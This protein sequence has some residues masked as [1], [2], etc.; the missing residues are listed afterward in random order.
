MKETGTVERDRVPIRRF[1]TYLIK[2]IEQALMNEGLTEEQ[3]RVADIVFAFNNHKMLELLQKRYK[4]LC[5]AKFEKAAIVENKLT[6][7]K[8]NQYQNLTI[9]NTYFCTFMEGEGSRKAANM[10]EIECDEGYK[11]KIEQ[12]KNPSNILWM[13]MGVPRWTQ[14]TIGLTVTFIILIIVLITY[15]VFTVEVSGQTYIHYRASP[16]GVN[17]DAFIEAETLDRAQRLASIEYKFLNQ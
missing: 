4:Y 11:L 7:L 1:K 17:C 2:M 8:N 3:S 15:F 9:P 13:N 16:P 5:D 12:A 14:V 10:K 6:D